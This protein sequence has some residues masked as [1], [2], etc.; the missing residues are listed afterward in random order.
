MSEDIFIFINEISE[1]MKLCFL[2]KTATVFW[3]VIL[4]G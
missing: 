1:E 2:V 4:S 3:N